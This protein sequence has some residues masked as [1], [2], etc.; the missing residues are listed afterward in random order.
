VNNAT[1]NTSPIDSL[2]FDDNQSENGETGVI[3]DGTDSTNA[4]F[5]SDSPVSIYDPT[6]NN[7]MDGNNVTNATFPADSPDSTYNQTENNDTDVILDGASSASPTILPSNSID[8]QSNTTQ[9]PTHGNE[10]STYYRKGGKSYWANYDSSGSR[11][12]H[13]IGVIFPFMLYNKST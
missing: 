10:F 6:D 3:T 13:T 1:N 11:S 12:F 8:D 4:T 7:D 5:P 2:E 9:S